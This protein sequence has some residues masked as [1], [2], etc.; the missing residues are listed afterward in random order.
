VPIRELSVM[1]SIP[2]REGEE[3]LRSGGKPYFA[4]VAAAA[5]KLATMEDSG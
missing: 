2:Y 4:E 3:V 5:A 1:F